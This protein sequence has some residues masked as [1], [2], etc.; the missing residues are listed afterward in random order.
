M[1]MSRHDASY[2]PLTPVQHGERVV[3][4]E[5][6][7]FKQVLG[8]DAQALP[9]LDI[10]QLWQFLAVDAVIATACTMPG[11]NVPA[12]IYF[13]WKFSFQKRH[14]LVGSSKCAF[15]NEV[16][17]WLTVFFAAY[18]RI[19][20]CWAY[21]DLA[22]KN[23]L[24]VAAEALQTTMI[25]DACWVGAVLLWRILQVSMI[26]VGAHVFWHKEQ[27]RMEIQKDGTD[28]DRKAL[29]LLKQLEARFP[30]YFKPN[31]HAHCNAEDIQREMSQLS[32]RASSLENFVIYFSTLCM[33]IGMLYLQSRTE[34]AVTLV[35]CADMSCEGLREV[36]IL[37][38]QMRLHWISFVHIVVVVYLSTRHWFIFLQGILFTTKRFQDNTN[39]LL[40]FT[41][42]SEQAQVDMWSAVNRKNLREILMTVNP[43]SGRS[44]VG[45]LSVSEVELKQQINRHLDG[46]ILDLKKMVDI[47]AWWKLRK[48]IQIDFVDE[49]AVMDFCAASS[50]ILF[51]SLASC[52]ILDWILNR[53]PFSRGLALIFIL[54]SALNY[55]ILR[56]FQVCVNINLL[57][58][59]D[60]RV[61]T[62]AAVDI[63]TRP[64]EAKQEVA[65]LL[66]ALQRK[67]EGF[68]DQQGLFG[69]KI[70]RHMRNGWASVD[71]V[72]MFWS[73]WQMFRPSMETM[74]VHD[75][76]GIVSN[77]T[78]FLPVV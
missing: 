11:V 35:R 72:V 28:S 68:D 65:T 1:T 66:L 45:H 31:H 33:F 54:V 30:Q 36:K 51:L 44:N 71:F 42:L 67:V 4:V 14:F 40:L 27:N 60:A 47:Q 48:Y 63:L 18:L 16:I 5:R 56:V 32:H 23:N 17:L 29:Q 2:A 26:E 58:E 15:V 8:E 41:A 53:D 59:R 12:S 46:D 37:G 49:S 7:V 70:T 38:K 6:D 69:L 13:L 50:T 3:R 57:L 78:S 73:A 19:R 22:S 34:E 25:S 76:E 55:A 24:K 43:T 9:I 77:L 75:M 52:G 61:L 74:E 64:G 20:N 39:Q 10:H 62:D 21:V